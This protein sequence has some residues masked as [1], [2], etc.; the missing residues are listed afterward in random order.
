MRP[1]YVSIRMA[2]AA[3]VAERWAQQYQ[4]PKDG[5]RGSAHHPDG[6]KVYEALIAL[7]PNPPLDKVAEIIGNQSWSY[8][9]C[10]GCSDYVERAVALGEYE[11][12]AYCATCISE[13]W[14]VMGSAILGETK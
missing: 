3:G 7:G 12:K 13:A 10:D 9:S 5:W 6:K 4:H 14:Q 8:I 1:K 2:T 11:P